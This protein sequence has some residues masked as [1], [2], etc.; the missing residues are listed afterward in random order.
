[1]VASSRRSVV[2][3]SRRTVRPY[4]PRSPHPPT[5]RS[6]VRL[7]LEA[8]AVVETHELRRVYKSATGVIRRRVK[9]TEA[10]RGISVEIDE[11][12]LFGL[13]GPNGAGKTT[14]IKILTTLLLPSSGKATV[15]GFDVARQA[16][17]VRRRIG[18]V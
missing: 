11:G 16:K 15:L 5:P 18:Y 6:R 17:E 13:L 9:T 7:R 10:V 2:R 12:E 1:M 3:V 14:T 4:P 8:M